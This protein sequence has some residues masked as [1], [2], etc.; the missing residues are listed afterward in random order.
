MKAEL[1]A[2]GAESARLA[3]ELVSREATMTAAEEGFDE[4]SRKQKADVARL[5]AENRR[6]ADELA[7]FQKGVDAAA[8]EARR[9]EEELRAQ[10]RDLEAALA[11][12]G[13]QLAESQ[14]R[15]PPTATAAAAAAPC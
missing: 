15:H 14:A 11:D 13:N 12:T 7:G 6:L 3:T 4:A 9:T 2:L 5:T 1:S 10:K 8:Q